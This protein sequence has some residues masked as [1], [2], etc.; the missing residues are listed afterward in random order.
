MPTCQVWCTLNILQE[1]LPIYLE[2]RPIKYALKHS[3]SWFLH[4][5]VK[6]N[7]YGDTIAEKYNE[8]NTHEEG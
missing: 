8:Q 1:Q 2:V 6:Y 7:M 5:W 3:D 4:I